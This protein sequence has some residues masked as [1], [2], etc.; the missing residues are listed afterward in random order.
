MSE[1]IVIGYDDQ[2]AAERAFATVQDLQRDYVVHLNGL[3]VVSV[4][5][6]GR[7]HVDT[8]SRIV[9]VSAASGA[10]GE[11]SSAFSSCCRGSAS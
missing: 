2:E 11:R 3:A 6:D 9:G 5:A 1:L 7:T 8:T 4:D 10:C